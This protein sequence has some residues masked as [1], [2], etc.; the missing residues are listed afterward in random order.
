[1]PS[2]CLVFSAC[3]T[4][5]LGPDTAS[6]AVGAAARAAG[7]HLKPAQRSK[8]SLVCSG[9]T[10]HKSTIADEPPSNSPWRVER[11]TKE[12]MVG[13]RRGDRCASHER[14]GSQLVPTSTVAVHSPSVVVDF[15]LSSS[16]YATQTAKFHV[17]FHHP[18]HRAVLPLHHAPDFPPLSCPA[19]PERRGTEACRSRRNDTT[20]RRDPALSSQLSRSLGR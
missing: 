15:T 1:M 20:G 14:A 17:S 6:E 16:D 10:L 4:I 3:P 19:N 2:P 8:P 18:S 7:L 9:P 11:E 5:D 12:Q 13:R